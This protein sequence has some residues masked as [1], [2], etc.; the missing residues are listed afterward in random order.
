MAAERVAND[1]ET[2]LIISV[3]DL[4][5]EWKLSSCLVLAIAAVIAPLLLLFGLKYGTIATLRSRLVEDPKNREIIP[6]STS[7]Y[8][9]EWFDAIAIRRDVT[10]LMPT[11]R[12]IAGSIDVSLPTNRGKKTVRLDIVPTGRGDVLLTEN[13]AIIPDEGECVLTRLAAEEIGAKPED[14]LAC[15]V[16]RSRQGKSETVSFSL[17]VIS[18]LPDRAGTRKALYVPLELVEAVEAY[19]DGR[20]VPR[21]DWPGDLPKA[22]PK[23]DG[24]VLLFPAPLPEAEKL[25]LTMGTGLSQVREISPAEMPDFLGFALPDYLSLTGYLLHVLHTPVGSD[26]LEAVNE[27]LRG[28]NAIALPYVKPIKVS[29]SREGV[30]GLYELTLLGYPAIS[31][32]LNRLGQSSL[33]AIGEVPERRNVGSLL[34]LVL[35]AAM[36]FGEVGQTFTLTFNENGRTLSFPINVATK[37][38]HLRPA[39]VP[40]DLMGILNAFRQREIFYSESE[41]E[42]LV[43]RLSYA[44]FRMYA[45]TIDDV[46]PLRR[47]LVAEGIE[48]STKADEIE[49]VKSMD[50]GLTRV[51]WLIAVVGIVGCMAALVASLAS[52]VERKKRDLSVLRLLGMSGWIVFQVPVSQAVCLGM[53]GFL[54]AT[55]VFFLIAAVINQVFAKDLLQGEKMCALAASHFAIALVGT[56][57]VVFFSSLFA[58]WQTTRI[59]PADALR[60]E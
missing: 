38:E 35:P 42:F 44:G 20:A 49:R 16:G 41:H 23:F 6:V 24:F 45:R 54:T 7:N 9:K 28:R 48:V 8:H 1:F 27:K 60:D 2:G 58:A 30:A 25:S 5:H 57:A 33:P 55:A 52:S 53:T 19:K 29:L 47:C 17:K 3:H 39:L 56:L 15:V 13:G 40:S 36:E 31:A 50:R 46:E 10:F 51:F 14:V 4:F 18:V 22:Y 21:Y 59:D 32:T 26:S 12:Q 43:G 11:T 34:Q 37:G